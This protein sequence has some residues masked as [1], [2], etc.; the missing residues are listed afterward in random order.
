MIPAVISPF[1]TE[2][3]FPNAEL[4][5]TEPNGLLAIGGDLDPARI[6]NAYRHGIFPWFSDDQPILWWSPD[7]RMILHPQELSVSRSLRKAIRKTEYQWSYDRAF[8]KVIH[9]C[10]QPRPKQ[11]ETWITS[12]MM[13]AYITLHQLG[14]AH[15]FETWHNGKLVGGLYGIAIGQ[16]FF[17]ESMFSHES[18][19]S[20]IAFV[21]AVNQLQQWGYQL[22]DCQV[23]SS[24]LENFGATNIPRLLFLD[25]IMRLSMRAPHENAWQKC[26]HL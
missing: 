15:S 18:N 22:I 1:D 13:N 16:V 4:A 20:K 3:Q 21:L 26:N 5:L 11:P 24:H 8:A 23:E 2:F 7:P 6:L 19:A 14:H 12:E 25:K 17:G 10:A 9:A